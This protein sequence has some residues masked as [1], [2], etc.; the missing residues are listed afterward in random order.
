M[1][2]FEFEDD[3][4]L[5][6]IDWKKTDESFDHEFGVY[7]GWGVQIHAIKMHSEAVTG[8]WIIITEIV[9][10]SFKDKLIEKIVA[11][12]EAA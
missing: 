1:K 6:E 11:A 2:T 5:Y 9:T 12:E 8:E 10:G 3:D 7:R 4:I